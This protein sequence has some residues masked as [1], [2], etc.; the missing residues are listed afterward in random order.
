[1]GQGRETCVERWGRSREG[2]S[3]GATLEAASLGATLLAGSARVG[4]FLHENG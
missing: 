2:A 3:L 4:P 1:M